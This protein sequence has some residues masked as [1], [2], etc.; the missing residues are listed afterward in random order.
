MFEVPGSACRPKLD[1]SAYTVALADIAVLGE[2]NTVRVMLDHGADVNAFDPLGRTPL[3][4]AAGSDV[5]PLDV[6]KL[7]SRTRRRRKRE[8]AHRQAAAIPD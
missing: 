6:V 7:L 4:Y 3:M 2:V 1:P 5:V 8:E